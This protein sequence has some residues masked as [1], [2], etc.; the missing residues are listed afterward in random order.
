M[1]AYWTLSVHGLS[2][3]EGENYING[4]IL[5][6]FRR[7]DAR[8]DHARADAAQVDEYGKYEY[9]SNVAEM[10]ERLDLMGFTI[11]RAAGDFEAGRQLELD[12][13]ASQRSRY[14]KFLRAYSFD[15]WLSTFRRLLR[16]GKFPDVEGRH[17]RSLSVQQFICN[18]KHDA[19]VGFFHSDPRSVLR[20]CLQAAPAGWPVRLDLVD[21]VN[22]GYLDGD[23]GE[24]V[25]LTDAAM[26]YSLTSPFV[27]LTEGTFDAWVLQ[28]TLVLV[29]P[30]L[31]DL[32]TFMDFDSSIAPGGAGHLVT[33]IKAFIGS[34]IKN[35]ILAV[36]DNDTAAHAALRG[37]TGIAIP[38][39]INW[40]TLP[41][42]ARLRSHPT[43]GPQGQQAA[44]INGRACSIELFFGPDIVGRGKKRKVV[45][46]KSYDNAMRQ[47]QGEVD[48][49]GTLQKKFREKV[50]SATPA[51]LISDP[52]WADIRYLW[53]YL[54]GQAQAIGLKMLQT[55]SRP[56]SMG[57]GIFWHVE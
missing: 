25:R 33:T 19:L 9:V 8:I 53:A 46:W 42:L 23:Q 27:I 35:R 11:G 45:R 47:Y 18:R 50:K 4:E 39:N 24:Y 37:L 16:H 49:K 29:Y 14:T 15:K 3:L 34:G 17:P 13:R 22:A 41:N 36:F 21:L 38:P 57:A 6:L 55:S 12:D 51:M 1:G 43:V 31:T 2:L 56:A 5:Q 26:E 32:F 20:G 54:R 40:C 28:R 10:R 52:A 30:H 48:D 44:D 7:E